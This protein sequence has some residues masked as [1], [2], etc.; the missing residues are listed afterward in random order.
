M[1]ISSLSALFSMTSFPPWISSLIAR[2]KGR[3][4]KMEWSGGEEQEDVLK[5]RFPI[6]SSLVSIEE[7]LGEDLE[8]FPSVFVCF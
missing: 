7:T 8:S 4:K 3:I 5:G 6:V 2:I 1:F